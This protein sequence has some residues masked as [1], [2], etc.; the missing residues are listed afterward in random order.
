MALQFI[1]GGSGAGKT[2]FLYEN[3]IREAEARPDQ[4]FLVI[5][6]EQ[7]TMQAQKEIVTLHPRRG[8]MNIDVVSFE[9]LA[10]R[11]F[12]ELAVVNPAVLDDM[13]KSMILR[14]V[15][16]LKGREMGVFR[17]HLGQTGFIG[18]LKSMLSELYQYG[19]SSERL[20]EMESQA[21]NPLLRAK[22]KDLAAVYR[23]FQEY[24]EEKF[25]TAEEILGEL[26]RVFPRSEKMRDSIVVLDGYTGFTPV[27]YRLLEQMMICCRDVKVAVTVEKA[28]KPYERSGIQNLFYMSKEI[29]CR[30]SAL[31]E[32]NHVRRERD[33]W[34]EKRPYPRFSGAELDFLERKLYRY[35][36]DSWEG[37]PED[38]LLYRALN[39]REEIAFVSNRIEIL[40]REKGL[41]YRDVAVVTGDLESYGREAAV[42]FEENGIPFF[43]DEKKSILEHPLVE[44]IR[45]AL[46]TVVR[47]FSYESMFRYLKCGLAVPPE[48]RE[49]CDRMEN[50]CLA[51]GVRG[52]KRWSSPWEQV[53]RGGKHINM[54]E[55]NAF[56]EKAAAPLLRLREG[57]KQENATVRTITAALTDFLTETGAEEKVLA[58]SERF[59]EQGEYQLADEYSQVYGLVMD[60]FDRLVAL[61][62]DEESSIREYSEILDAG[63]GE[64]QVGVIPATVDRVVVGDI[65]RTR[66]DH[67]QVLF[68]VGVNDGIVPAKREK[69][70]ILSETDRE[71][72]EKNDLELAPTARKESFLQRFYL[73]LALTKPERK[74][75]L[76]FASMNQAGKGLR[77]SSL[78]RELMKLFPCLRLRE[79]GEEIRIASR[80]EGKKALAERLREWD[81][82][83]DSELL[84]LYRSFW[85]RE[86]DRA[87]LKEL[88]EAAFYSYEDR[89]IGRAAA[90]EL[91][92]KILSGSVTRLEQ[93]EACAYAHFLSYGLELSERQ[94]Y[95]LKSADMGNLFHSAIDTAFQRAM[96]SGRRLQDM[97]DAER[98]ALADEAAE[99]A[100]SDYGG[101]IMKSSARNIY[102]G[103]KVG[104]ITRRTLWALAEQL[105]K[106][107]F[108][109]AGFEVSFSAIDNLK[110]MKISLT[111][112][113]ALHLRGRI[114]RM[115]LCEDEQHVYVKIIDYKS[116]KTSF[117]LA[118]LYYGLQ[119]QLVVYLDAAM[120]LME[121][122]N[123]G[124]E[125]VPAGVFYYHIDDPVVD[126]EDVFGKE[127]ADRLVLQKLRM[128]G[129][130]NDDSE[131]I[132]LMDRKMEGPSDVI[133]VAMSCGK[134]QK[135][136]SSVA[137][138]E[139]FKALRGF[140]R[141]TMKQA[142]TD[143]L[144]GNTAVSPYKQGNQTACDY[145]P[146]H[147]VCGFDR[148]LPGYEYRK[149]RKLKTEEIWKK[150]EG[151]DG[152]G[153]D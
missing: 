13:G 122:R 21:P 77:P 129:L 138:G 62:G 81:G 91:Y 74:L 10:Y 40:V 29:V 135:V 153:R 2:R 53:Y 133:P 84:E 50:Y 68:F 24:I 63:F 42:Q 73:Y 28:A 47:D 32:K 44:L 58:W 71:F 25:I 112:D 149:M 98:D 19:V 101:E 12:E 130:V 108:T 113:E 23:G 121:K 14:K 48:E 107:K 145:C 31:A 92:G 142:G 127:D 41:R 109:P 43:L 117:D 151:K 85:N 116:G 114:D 20:E 88:V 78:V 56:R 34:V 143:I 103:K 49:L 54:E 100:V 8:T 79:A 94:E 80:Q 99:T 118:A 55:L 105:K 33:C 90:R 18:Q 26:C 111:E 60:L 139:R 75:I 136:G 22:L 5:V 17:G 87:W 69:G 140:V 131:V 16:A 125:I 59:R 150:I 119:L 148:H 7:F 11:V 6:P 106:G 132:S 45:A 9:R 36:R 52:W 123:P 97:D 4:Q 64:I 67:I 51:L 72:L 141:K 38:V 61:L 35:S 89:G 39:P 93:Y 102:L 134:V 1:M 126:G 146:Y 144:C 96:K 66:L 37:V 128:D 104:R 65:T 57:L 15:T 152:E 83:K 115:D 82:R 95:E 110:A 76:S 86:E 3:L 147:S 120:E 70:G 137:D 30:L 46:E 124:K 27:Q